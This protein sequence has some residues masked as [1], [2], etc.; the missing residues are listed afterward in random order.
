MELVAKK[1]LFWCFY[2]QVWQSVLKIVQ[3]FTDAGAVTGE[4]LRKA[5]QKARE[6]KQRQI[7]IIGISFAFSFIFIVL[8]IVIIQKRRNSSSNQSTNTSSPQRHMTPPPGQKD[9]RACWGAFQLPG[10]LGFNSSCRNTTTLS[11]V[12]KNMYQTIQ[13]IDKLLLFRMFALLW[14]SI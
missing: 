1:I 8:V 5:E 3:S 11:E 10:W 13:A 12:L 2:L 9:G 7:M 4:S 14:I 6:A